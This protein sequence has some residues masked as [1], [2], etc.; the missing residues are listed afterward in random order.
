MKILV[1]GASGYAGLHAAIALRAAGHQVHGLVR[2]ATTSRAMELRRNEVHLA[3][4][5]LK[6]PETYWK[7]LESSDAII[8]IVNDL[9][10]PQ[11]TDNTL[12]QTM[13]TVADA[14][15]RKRLFIYTTGCSVYGKVPERV[16]DET[17]PG[18]PQHALAFRMNMEQKVLAMPN[19]RTVVVRPGFLYGKDGHTSM[20]GLWFQMGEES[21]AVYQG[22]PER[23]WSWVHV[24]D[25]AEAYVR[26]A[27]SSSSIDGEIFCLA[28]EQRLKCLEVMTAC[29]RAAGFKGDIQLAHP[30]PSDWSSIFDQNEF[31]TSR[32]AYRLLG[33]SPRH[34]GIL[35]DIET[36]YASWKSAQ[37]NDKKY[38]LPE[39]TLSSTA[40]SK[41]VP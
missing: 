27:E 12:L 6:Q 20:S 19:F 7:H 37:S 24:S 29:V 9:Q 3:E 5:N 22:D 13:A 40:T 1:T 23:G 16:M 17:T 31:I 21:K 8:H 33:W 25:L 35:D 2:D 36:Y 34:T 41:R 11:G 39:N 10:D 30:D 4:G 28:D 38:T 26:L 32:K 14:S 18:N 15:P